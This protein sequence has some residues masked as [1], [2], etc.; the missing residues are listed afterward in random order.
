MHPL[1]ALLLYLFLVL[2]S[3]ALAAPFLYHA[4]NEFLTYPF[5]RYVNRAYLIAAI[6]WLPLLVTLLKIP[7]AETIGWKPSSQPLTKILIALFAG[8]ISTTATILIHTALGWHIPNEHFY[9]LTPLLA[10][11]LPAIL[12]APVEEILFRGFAQYAFCRALSTSPALLLTS[13]SFATL[14]FIK[15]P[16][17]PSDA[18]V[19]TLS[20][21]QALSEAAYRAAFTC[22]T[23]P[24]GLGLL[25]AGL[26]LS[27][28]RHT[29]DS[30]WLPIG[31]HAAWILGQKATMRAFHPTPDCPPWCENLISSPIAWLAMVLTTTFLCRAHTNPKPQT[32]TTKPS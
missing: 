4:L 26:C 8:L 17:W 29:S 32:H 10:G 7:S 18:P 14:H 20:G 6:L 3:A 12:V 30:L 24:R 15:V 16:P 31:L 25:I 27:W 19:T 28:L 22:F 5:H 11:L 9:T 21:L 1:A 2:F 13:I 23:E